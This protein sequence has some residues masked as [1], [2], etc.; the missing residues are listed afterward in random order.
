MDQTTPTDAAAAPMRG[1]LL[2]FKRIP[3]ACLRSFGIANA[4]WQHNS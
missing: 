4:A 3:A 2:I 1:E